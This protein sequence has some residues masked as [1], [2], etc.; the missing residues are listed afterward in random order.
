MIV[1]QVFVVFFHRLVLLLWL[2]S[3]T[4]FNLYLDVWWRETQDLMINVFL[5]LSTKLCPARRKDNE[6]R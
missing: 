2:A 6:G 4:L 3:L 5:I 1:N